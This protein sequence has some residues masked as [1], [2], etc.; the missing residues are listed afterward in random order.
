M[1]P[2]AS[3][4]LKPN[5]RPANP[6]CQRTFRA[7]IG[8]LGHLRT[9]CSTQTTPAAVSSS[10]SAD[11]QHWPRSRT[12]IT[13]LLL[14]LLSLS[15]SSSSSSLALASTTAAPVPPTS[16]NSSPVTIPATWTLSIPVLITTAPLP[17]K[18]AWSVTCESFARRLTNQCL[19][20]RTT[21]AASASIVH[22]VPAHSI[23]AW[24]FQGACVFTKTCG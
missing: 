14:L 4:P 17:H 13:I 15:S 7:P 23:T 18:S 16:I 10:S 22:T 19:K 6:R 3:P 24:A 1:K 12:P 9:N 5:A 2:T 11:S 21:L 20:H 8:L